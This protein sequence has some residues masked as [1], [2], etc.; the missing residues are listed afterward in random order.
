MSEKEKIKKPFDVN[1][2]SVDEVRR[3]YKENR[4]KM[5]RA[6]AILKIC[7][8]TTIIFTVPAAFFT[9]LYVLNRLSYYSMSGAFSSFIGEDAFAKT[10]T[11]ALINALPADL[12][13]YLVA[14]AVLTIVAR[15]NEHL[16]LYKVL[17]IIFIVGAVYSAAS[18]P[19]RLHPMAG[20]IIWFIY[21][22]L[23]V[24]SIYL[25]L[26]HYDIIDSLKDQQG[27]PQFL[28]HFDN[29]H[30]IKHT[31]I[32]FVDYQKKM[33][34]KFAAEKKIAE[35][36]RENLKVEPYEEEFTP[37]IIGD[38]VLPEINDG[39]EYTNILETRSSDGNY[40]DLVSDLGGD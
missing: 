38:L 3:V 11:A 5:Q 25:I 9:F 16:K 4:E 29:S 12:L 6:L 28:D 15:V 39:V 40:E 10:N 33:E 36:V 13:V 35:T 20:C 14:I 22:C 2:D 8:T 21:S 32:K 1:W 19:L 7:F 34:Q 24:F 23:G 31:S 30:G 17:R 18:L 26:K 27:F 37:G